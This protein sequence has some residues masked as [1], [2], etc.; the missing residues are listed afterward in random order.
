MCV[1]KLLFK[2]T[3]LIGDAA[4]TARPHVG[5]GVSKAASDAMTFTLAMLS[6]DRV[7]SLKRWEQSRL[8]YARA[9]FQ[10][11]RDLGSYIGEKTKGGPTGHRADFYNKPTTLISQNASNRPDHYIKYYIDK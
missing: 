5:L 4:C 2:K 1:T 8:K 10:W 9:V 6:P 11:S 3:V 7:E